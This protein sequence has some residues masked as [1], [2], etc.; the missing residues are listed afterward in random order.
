M[1]WK[2]RRTLHLRDFF[3]H[4]L[5]RFWN[6]V[7]VSDCLP[8]TRDTEFVIRTVTLCICK[9]RCSYGEKEDAGS[10]DLIHFVRYFQI[11]FQRGLHSPHLWIPLPW[12]P[13]STTCYQTWNHWCT[14]KKKIIIGFAIT[15]YFSVRG[16]SILKTHSWLFFSASS[17]PPA[18]EFQFFL[19]F[20]VSHS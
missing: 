20:L 2:E 9:A 1:D 14:G 6:L 13:I 16:L 3:H 19:I 11:A 18:E 8:G 15:L 17:P 10:E 7:M 5:G 12:M 4:S